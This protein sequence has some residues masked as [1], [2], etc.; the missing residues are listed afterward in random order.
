M[1]KLRCRYQREKKTR[2]DAT[3]RT[4]RIATLFIVVKVLDKGLER[5]DGSSSIRIRHF[6]IKAKVVGATVERA[7]YL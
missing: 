3:T 1:R 5:G 6:L 2:K 7:V 4:I